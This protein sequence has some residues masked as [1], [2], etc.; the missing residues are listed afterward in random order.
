MK[1][2]IISRTRCRA[3]P[4]QT[5]SL[6]HPQRTE[7]AFALMTITIGDN[8][9]DPPMSSLYEGKP[10]AYFGN[11]RLDIVDRLTTGPYSSVLEL[12]CGAGGTGKAVLDAGKAG[13]YVGIELSPRAAEIAA[14]RLT[15]VVVGDVHDLDLTSMALRFDALIISEVL[16]HLVDPW[17]SLRRLVGCLKPGGSIYASSP[18][19]S[20]WTVIRELLSGRFQYQEAGFMDRTHLRWFTPGSYR[21]LFETSGVEVL[22]L[23]SLIPLR[24]KARVIDRLTGGRFRHLF[25]G[26]IMLVGRKP[27][28]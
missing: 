27:L 10:E 8:K 16:E 5:R 15:E 13:S 14:Q 26:Q 19:L 3:A 12:G 22:E 18:N 11:A 7:K 1:R 9:P 21:E 20:H 28:G 6:A 4:G 23:G 24:P 2:E 25:I 17:S